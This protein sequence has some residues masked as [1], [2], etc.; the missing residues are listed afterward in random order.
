MT[1]E[2]WVERQIR[3]AQE[4]GAF[5]NLTGAGKPLSDDGDG[6]DELWWIKRKVREEGLSFTTAGTRPAPGGR[7]AVRVAAGHD[8][9][10][11]AEGTRRGA[12]ALILAEWRR[13]QETSVY[14]PRRVDVEALVEEWWRLRGG[15]SS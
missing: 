14:P 9:R 5:E 6:Y 4:R 1:F 12:Q 13:P 7:A 11:A 3:E 2:S 8:L 10:A 15:A